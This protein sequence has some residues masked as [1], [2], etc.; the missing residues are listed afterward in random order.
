MRKRLLLHICCAP[1][2]TVAPERL[3]QDYEITAYFYNPNIHPEEEYRLRL[4]EMQRLAETL[5]LPLA[6]GAYSVPQWQAWIKGLEKE[7]EGGGRCTAC[8]EFRLMN[9]AEFAKAHGYDAFSTVLTVSPHKQADTINKAGTE[10]G[11]RAGVEFIP[12][13]LKKKGGFERSVTLSRHYGLYR[14]NY[15]GCEYSKSPRS[16]L[17]QR[18]A[19]GLTE[20]GDTP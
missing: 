14:Q 17:S 18:G 2:A 6:S 8:F 7:P 13:N 11:R 19:W 16:P 5:H 1:D 12:L 10:A 15:C 20:G 9:V 3:S 4:S